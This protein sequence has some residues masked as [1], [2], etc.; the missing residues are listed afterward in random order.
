MGFHRALSWFL[1]ADPNLM[2][3]SYVRGR[4]LEGGVTLLIRSQKQPPC[5]RIFWKIFYWVFCF[6][7]LPQALL[8]G[9]KQVLF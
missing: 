6:Q 5:R 2:D 7:L 1:R 4:A 9:T 8:A 3:E